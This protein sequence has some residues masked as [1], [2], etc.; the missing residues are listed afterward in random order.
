MSIYEYECQICGEEF[1][2]F[3]GLN[4]NDKRVT[5]PMCGEKEVKRVMSRAYTQGTST[6]GNLRFPT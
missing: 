2:S 3:K 1:E 4:D 6:R 5:C